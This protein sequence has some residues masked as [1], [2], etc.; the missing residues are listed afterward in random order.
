GRVLRPAGGRSQAGRVPAAGGARLLAPPGRLRD[1]AVRRAV[2]RVP[3]RLDRLRAAGHPGHAGR[4]R[5]LLRV[6]PDGPVDDPGRLQHD[7]HHHQLPS[8]RDA[9]EPTPDVRLVDVHGLVPAGP[10]G[11]RTRGRV[12]HGA[13]GP[14]LPD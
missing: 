1:P 2:R 11:T 7:R 14:D 12:L 8:P 9:V 6:R 4:G 3:D 13:D 10:G 5:V